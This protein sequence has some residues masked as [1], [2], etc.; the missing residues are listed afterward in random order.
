MTNSTPHSPLT[1]EA[2][3][4]IDKTDGVEDGKLF[5]LAHWK[6]TNERTHWQHAREVQDKVSDRV[7]GFAG[8]LNFV[9]LHTLWFVIWISLNVGLIGAS[10]QFDEYPFG[11]L[12]MIVSLEAIFL[13]T[14]VLVSQNRL[15]ARANIRSQVDFESN[16]QSLI[17]LVHLAHKSNV[18]VAHVDKLC[19]E[20]IA[21][22][23]NL[24]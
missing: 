17:W 10:F 7:T 16:L 23:R 3:R 1:C 5:N 2:C 11:L 21:E 22:S 18:D 14:F 13:S 15:A 12:T 4:I 24:A 9:Y 19:A 20:A 6:I 8:S